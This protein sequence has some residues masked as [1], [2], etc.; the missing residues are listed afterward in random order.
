MTWYVATAEYTLVGFKSLRCTP[1]RDAATLQAVAA[2]LV[3]RCRHD[4]VGA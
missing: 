3:L 2:G 1:Q 4:I